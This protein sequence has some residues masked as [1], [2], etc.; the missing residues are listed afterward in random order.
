MRCTA[1]FAPMPKLTPEDLEVIERACRAFAYRQEE[2][3]KK[4]G[5]PTI[6]GPVE[7]VARH[8]AELAERFARA[9]KAR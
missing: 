6:R 7:R 1:P 4:I 3:A 8:A 2:D 5:N 9:R